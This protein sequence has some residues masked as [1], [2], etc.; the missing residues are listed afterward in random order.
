[1]GMPM[2]RFQSLYPQ[3]YGYTQNYNYSQ[4]REGV[5]KFVNGKENVEAYYL[6]PNS[7]DVFFDKNKPRFYI[8][9]VDASG[10]Q[11]V[12]E[13]DFYEVEDTTQNASNADYITRQEFEEWKKNYEP[14]ISTTATT[15]TE[16]TT[17]S[18]TSQF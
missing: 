2:N 5:L 4:N 14:T 18:T 16:P 3:N 12:Y 8:K 6:P 11:N 13:Y 15:T 10:T 9:K 7:Q 17:K 1:M